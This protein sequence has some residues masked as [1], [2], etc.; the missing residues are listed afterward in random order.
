MRVH[1]ESTMHQVISPLCCVYPCGYLDPPRTVP[2][3]VLLTL[4]SVTHLLSLNLL[5]HPTEK[6]ILVLEW[7]NVGFINLHL[8][9]WTEHTISCLDPNPTAENNINIL[10]H[11]PEVFQCF[12]SPN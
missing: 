10:I 4:G 6:D 1:W 12:S 9:I 7:R 11:F 2:A 3:G 5:A 8:Y